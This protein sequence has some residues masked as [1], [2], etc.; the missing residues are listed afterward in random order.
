M[1]MQEKTETKQ[2]DKPKTAYPTD[3]ELMKEPWLISAAKDVNVTPREMLTIVR[4]E[5]LI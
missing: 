3:E 4:N 2:E 1:S 5:G